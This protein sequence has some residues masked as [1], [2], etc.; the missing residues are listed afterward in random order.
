MSMCL[1]EGSF[2]KICRT[3]GEKFSVIFVIKKK[4]QKKKDKKKKEVMVINH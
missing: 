3:C 4:R 2:D 1:H